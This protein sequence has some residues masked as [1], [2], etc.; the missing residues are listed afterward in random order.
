MTRC[1]QH[2]CEPRVTGRHVCNNSPNSVIMPP[3]PSRCMS[4]NAISMP[5][6]LTA[7]HAASNTDVRLVLAQSADIEC[8]VTRVAYVSPR[9][10][11]IMI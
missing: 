5:N 9:S 8:Q 7:S 1:S 10:L 6:V 2:L 11:T 3:H 4:D